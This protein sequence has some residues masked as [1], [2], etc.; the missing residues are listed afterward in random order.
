MDDAHAAGLPVAVWTVNDP[1]DIARFAKY[2]VDAIV[3][4][5]PDVAADVLAA[6]AAPLEA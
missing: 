3:T 1:E 5:Y 4:D 2:G 6:A